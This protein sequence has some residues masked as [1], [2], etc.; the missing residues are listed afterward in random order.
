MVGDTENFTS[1][2]AYGLGM[3]VGDGQ[4]YRCAAKLVVKP[5]FNDPQVG[6]A[7][8]FREALS[9]FKSMHFFPNHVGTDSQVVVH[10]SNSRHD[11]SSYFSMVIKD[12]KALLQDLRFVSYAFV[13]KSVNQVAYA[14]TRAAN[15]V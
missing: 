2:G 14:I 10:A 13:R 9:W 1:N 5:G 6:E 3:L 11:F 7:L 15:S 12:C 8:C 4:G